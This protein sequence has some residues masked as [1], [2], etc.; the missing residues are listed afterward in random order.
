M[1]APREIFVTNHNDFTHTDRFNG[2]DYVFQPKQKVL[3][4]IDAAEH[5]FGFGKDD[6][7]ETLTRLGWA[8]KY[9][10][11]TKQITESVEGPKW[12]ARFQFTQ[13]VMVEVGVTKASDLAPAETAIDLMGEPEAA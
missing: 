7:T 2:V 4:P 5:M 11:A 6:K 3:I 13:G 8:N 1:L 10:P 9:D 12:L